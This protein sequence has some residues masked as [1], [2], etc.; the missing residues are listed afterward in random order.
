MAA[1]VASAAVVSVGR[2]A[3]VRQGIGVQGHGR[4]QGNHAA[5]QHLGRG[6]QSDALIGQDVAGEQGGAAQHCRLAHLP[7][8]ALVGTPSNH[9]DGRA[10]AGGQ[11]AA[12]L[13]DEQRVGIIQAIEPERARQLGR[14]LEEIDTRRER[15]ATEVSARQHAGDGLAP[16]QVVGRE[17]I[18][19]GLHRHRIGLVDRAHVGDAAQAGDRRARVLAQITPKGGRAGVDDG[20]RAQHGHRLRRPQYWQ[21]LSCRCRQGSGK[22]CQPMRKG[23]GTK[24]LGSSHGERGSNCSDT[25]ASIPDRLNP[26]CALRVRLYVRRHTWRGL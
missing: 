8:D 21:C 16:E 13:E 20:G 19:L 22:Q 11:G 7:V 2:Q 14:R 4:M 5:A 24:G 1:E 3:V 17:R 9:V 6:V 15:Q 23:C 10:A 25:G 26:L 12:D 18:G